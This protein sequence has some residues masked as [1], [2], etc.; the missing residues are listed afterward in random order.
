MY[1]R[2]PVEPEMNQV[3]LLLIQRNG[4]VVVEPSHSE[5]LDSNVVKALSHKFSDETKAEKALL[6]LNAKY[7]LSGIFNPD[8]KIEN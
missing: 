4:M 7:K 2:K 5:K 1:G 6:E 3:C 8:E